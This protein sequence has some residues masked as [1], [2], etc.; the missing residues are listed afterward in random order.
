MLSKSAEKKLRE[1]RNASVVEI[2][3]IGDSMIQ[4]QIL[5]DKVTDVYQSPG[6]EATLKDEKQVEKVLDALM[7]VLAD[8]YQADDN[9][10]DFLN[11]IEK[12]VPFK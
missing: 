8:L 12:F 5:V 9:A 4:L 7:G 3:K 1:V 6:R 10:E 11:Q 2:D